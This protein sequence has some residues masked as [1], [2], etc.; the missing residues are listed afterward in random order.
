MVLNMKTADFDLSIVTVCRNAKERLRDTVQSVL[1][2]KAET[3][4]KVQHLLIDGMSTDGSVELLREWLRKAKIEGYVSEPDKGIYDAMNKGIRLAR[5][6]VLYFLNAGDTLLST[7]AL[8]AS[9]RPLL[10]GTASHAAAPVLSIVDGVQQLEPPCYE[11]V[12]LSTPCC[13]Q[14]YFATA[15]L[16]RSLGGYD[17]DFYR[18]L[19]DADFMSKAYARVGMPHVENEPVALYPTDGFSCNC[20]FHFLPEYIEMARRNWPAILSRCKVEAEYRDMVMGVL[21]DRCLELARWRQEKRKDAAA[22]VAT[23]QYQLRSLAGLCWHPLR[24]VGLRWAAAGYL[25]R[26]LGE[27]SVSPCREKAMYWVRIVCSMRPGNRYAIER[28]YPARSLKAALWA[29]FCSFFKR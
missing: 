14:G 9:V 7:A 15:E 21:A 18:C 29:K 3:R 8:E 10:S 16:Y 25:P 23:L 26:V 27:A 24:Y 12:Y 17:A 2:V 22:P 5:G 4:L 28:G 13:H 19:A 20:V 11:Y 1:A 6:K